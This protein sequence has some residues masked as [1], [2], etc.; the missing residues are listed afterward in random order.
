MNCVSI[1]FETANH[2]RTSICAV[3]I[4]IVRESVV[5]DTFYALIRPIRHEFHEQFVKLH[6]ITKEKVKE[7]PTFDCICVEL[8]RHIGSGPLVSHN[9]PF[10][11]GVLNKSLKQINQPV[12]EIEYFCTL[13]LSRVL[14]PELP[15]HKLGTISRLLKIPLEHHN[16]LSDAIAC[17]Q[18]AIHMDRIAKPVIQM[19][20]LADYGEISPVCRIVSSC[21]QNVLNELAPDVVNFIN[22]FKQPVPLQR[23]SRFKDMR[24][25]LTGEMDL[26]GRD[27]AIKI[28]NSCGGRITGSVSKKTNIVVVGCNEWNIYKNKGIAKTTKLSKAI[29]LRNQG[30]NIRIVNQTLFYDM[31]Q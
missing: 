22:F 31:I 18:I 4:A 23:D 21:K 17:A 20:N 5:V 6:G 27:Q 3:G 1:D 9:A 24:F 26:L 28:I 7:A 13:Q 10:D 25:V 19:N 29:E 11:M 12:P 2:D 14:L 30:C 15:N 8:L 16:A